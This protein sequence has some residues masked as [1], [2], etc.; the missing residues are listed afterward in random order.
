MNKLFR[1]FFSSTFSDFVEERNALNKKVFPRLKELCAAH[2]AR[3]QPI[4][5]RWGIPDEAALQQSTMQ[6]C[7]EE[8]KRC[9]N[10]TPRPNFLVL[11]GDR[12]GWTPPPAKIPKT[13]Y[14]VI[15]A[16]FS[17]KEKKLIE[18]WYRLDENEL[19]K[20]DDN[21]IT[22]VYEIQPRGKAHKNYED[23]DPMENKIRKILLDA[24]RKSSISKKEMLK[25]FASAT[26]QEIVL[27]ALNT[28]EPATHVLQENKGIAKGS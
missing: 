22:P 9:Q 15:S 21:T 20:L 4:D 10:L 11:L 8:I 28:A 17:K 23:W 19:S 25:Y 5:L 12:Y 3:F 2:G 16:H 27:G 18:R 24:A 13:E 1:V 7:L 14:D 26:H 6:I